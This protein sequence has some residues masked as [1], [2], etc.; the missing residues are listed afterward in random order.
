MSC[1]VYALKLTSGTGRPSS[2][3][4]QAILPLPVPP[5]QTVSYVLDGSKAQ[6]TRVRAGPSRAP[7]GVSA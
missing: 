1:A 4:K 5:G 6:R 2:G 3:P 7:A